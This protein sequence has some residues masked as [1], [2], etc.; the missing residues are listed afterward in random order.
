MDLQDDDGAA[1][2]GGK[3]KGRGG[4]RGRG[5]GGGGGGGSKSREVTV[6]RALSKLLRHQAENAGIGLD[7]EGYAALDEVVSFFFFLF[8]LFLFAWSH[9]MK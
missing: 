8:C 5:G 1:S 7:G 2:Q 9:M 6:S 4:V 3:G